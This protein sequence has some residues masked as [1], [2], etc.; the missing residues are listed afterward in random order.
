MLHKEYNMN[1][2]IYTENSFKLAT[3]Y[4]KIL[5]EYLELLHSSRLTADDYKHI[6]EIIV[7]IKY[8][9]HRTYE[10]I[11]KKYGNRSNRRIMRTNL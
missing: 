6:C 8:E 1:T 4:E 5:I 2:F 11:V 7:A 3:E 9:L 10:T